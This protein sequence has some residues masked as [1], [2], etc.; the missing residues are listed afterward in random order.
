MIV[1]QIKALPLQSINN[2]N[3]MKSRQKLK[4]QIADKLYFSEFFGGFSKYKILTVVSVDDKLA[5][6]DNGAI[7]VRESQNGGVLQDYFLQ[8]FENQKYPSYQ[9][10]YLCDDKK[11]SQANDA[12]KEYDEN[13]DFIKA[14]ILINN[15]FSG[16]KILTKEEKLAIYNAIVK[17]KEDDEYFNNLL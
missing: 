9:R 4:L 13:K 14:N 3:N 5:E 11:L 10:W 12:N 7:F 15:I 6:M 1:I 2:C 16:I 17:S 8:Y